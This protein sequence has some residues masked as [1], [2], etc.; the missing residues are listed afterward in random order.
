[1]MPT[2]HAL[3]IEPMVFKA[4]EDVKALVA[5]STVFDPAITQRTFRISAPEHLYLTLLLPLLAELEH[6][7]PN[8]KIDILPQTP[9][10][11]ARLE[12]GDIDFLLAQEQTLSKDHPSALLFEE[13]YVVAGW[14]GN[15]VFAE[16]LTEEAFLSCGQILVAQNQQMPGFCELEM[17]DLNRRRRIELTCPSLMSVP[18]LLRNSMRLAVMPE[19]TAKLLAETEPLAITPLPGSWAPIRESVQHHSARD[20]DQGTQWMLRQILARAAQS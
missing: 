1:M 10:A 2:A 20:I 7:A 8:L 14:N 6:K 18:W 16:P 4:L 13:R 12:N 3:S 15:P 17:R 9:D 11:A 19:R 5:A